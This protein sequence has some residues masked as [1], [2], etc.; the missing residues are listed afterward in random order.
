MRFKFETNILQFLSALGTII[1]PILSYFLI[2]NE[3]L[4]REAAIANAAQIH[5]LR[6]EVRI[7]KEQLKLFGEFSSQPIT[8]LP[9]DYKSYGITFFCVTV[10]IF[11][12]LNYYS[13]SG[14]SGPNLPSN[15]LEGNELFFTLANPKSSYVITQKLAEQ[16]SQKL[17]TSN[18]RTI[19]EF[20][21]MPRDILAPTIKP[22]ET[23]PADVPDTILRS[24]EFFTPW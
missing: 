4:Q 23:L 3:Q 5:L 13:S 12:F 14:G 1:F 17:L 21:E 11:L 18:F 22:F 8:D 19:G 15:G 16:N 6:E 7:L 24:L 10:A 9:P 2:L 20:G